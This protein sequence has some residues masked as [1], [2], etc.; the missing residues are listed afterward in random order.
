MDNGTNTWHIVTLP[1]MGV[2][3]SGKCPGGKVE[4]TPWTT[5]Q[6]ELHV[7][8]GGRD[9]YTLIDKLIEG[10]V[11]LPSGLTHD[12]MLTTDRFFLLYQLRSVS[13]VSKY[14]VIRTC[15]CKHEHEVQV[16]ID[17]LKVKVPDEG[18]S[19]P[20]DVY[21]PR[22]KKTVALRLLRVA[23]EKATREQGKKYS[24]MT[25]GNASSVGTAFTLARQILTIDGESKKFDE[26]RDFVSKL[27]L[28]D[29]AVIRNA[30]EKHETGLLTS[31]E[32]TCPKCGY[33]DSEWEVPLQET[34]FRLSE[35]DIRAAL[36]VDG[37][38]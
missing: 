30:V 34:F 7:T 19:E 3:Y 31:V 12:E 35:S 6:E 38:R 2:F 20:F 13:L 32:A 27:V 18:E 16:D 26:R 9:P 5:A 14:T 22:S 36:E 4:I 25:G 29:L 10:N 21:L 28:L 37:K 8:Y 17:A 24:T 23:D 11:R 15:K 33:V 1:S